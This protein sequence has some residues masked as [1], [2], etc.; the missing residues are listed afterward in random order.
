MENKYEIPYKKIPKTSI[1]KYIS[2]WEALNTPD[3]N[4]MTADWHP[5]QIW[6]STP[7]APGIE[8]YRSNHILG[9]SGI[10]KRKILYSQGESVYIAN[11]P[12]AIAD[13]LFNDD[14]IYHSQLNGCVDDFLTDEEAEELYRYALLIN[15]E[16]NIEWFLK[17][18]L[19]KFY[20]GEN[21]KR[22]INNEKWESAKST[23]A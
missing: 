20:F 6:L 9:T 16:K 4:G 11:F 13:I 21:K 17:Y 3:K 2:G 23:T 1:R 8:L 10:E 5:D 7:C 18:E 12:R 15:K 19:T 14:S 22:G